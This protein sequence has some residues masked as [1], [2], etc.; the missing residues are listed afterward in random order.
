MTIELYNNIGTTIHGKIDVADNL[1]HIGHWIRIPAAGKMSQ[2]GLYVVLAIEHT[3]TDTRTVT[4]CATAWE[5]SPDEK[6]NSMRRLMDSF[7][8]R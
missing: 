8:E 5:T 4:S 6:A 7:E 2:D 3:A 1:V